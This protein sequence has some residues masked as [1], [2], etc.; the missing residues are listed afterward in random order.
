[1]DA[2]RFISRK[3]KF[4]GNVAAVSI[5][6]SFLVIILA[7]TI[8]SGFRHAVRDGVSSLTGDIRISARSVGLTGET[9][10]I[11]ARLSCEE[12]LLALPGIRSIDPVAVRAGIVR[13]GDVIHGVLVKGIAGRPDSSLCVS[14]PT[15]LAAV[16]GLQAGD[17]MTTYFVGE[18]VRVR[19]F[20]VTE[21]H[22]DMLEMDDNLV[23][24]ANLSDIQRLNGWGE[25][26]AS[27]LE[28]TLRPEYK[29]RP[30]LDELTGQ[31]G[32]LLLLAGNDGEEDLLAT[33]SVQSYPQLFDWLDLVDF[34]VLFILV[35]MIIVAGFN[36]ISGLLIMLLRH[37]STIGTLKTLGMGDRA[38]GKVF[39][40][41]AS[42]VVGK[43]MLVGNAVALLF[44]GVQGATHLIKL[45]P[46]NYF[47]SYVPVHIDIPWIL[48][49]D[50]AAWVGIMLLLLIPTL[51]I[52]R[53]DPAR[54][55][56]AE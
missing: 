7:V 13:S 12:S 52:A 29:A 56:R 20:H 5:A 16:T 50:L 25:D 4:Q 6:V 8:A 15:R 55:V 43:G 33:S 23:V 32:T 48:A 10:P 38:I 37:I 51:F 53:V 1:M 11:P 27:A 41:V 44:C 14:I 3:L 34:N 30:V 17:D 45:D 36:M 18:K 39:L 21:V 22:R 31:I 2:T 54:T 46:A 28:V 24:Y 42:G 49:A 9:D 47:V 40:R 35:L 19:K 26:G